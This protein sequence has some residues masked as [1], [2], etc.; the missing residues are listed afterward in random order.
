MKTDEEGAIIDIGKKQYLS[1]DYDYA[2]YQVED[3]A[4]TVNFVNNYE[5]FI[6]SISDFDQY[7]YN[8]DEILILTKLGDIQAT[9]ENKYEGYW[10]AKCIDL[11]SDIGPGD[12]GSICIDFKI[13]PSPILG[14]L[15]GYLGKEDD[16]N[17]TKRSNLQ[18]LPIKMMD[19]DNLKYLDFSE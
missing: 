5:V 19:F 8:E 14:I 18:I 7:E 17:E 6:P 12:S 3:I 13:K 16:K 9:I 1:D 15:L 2:F 4:L 11:N 10:R